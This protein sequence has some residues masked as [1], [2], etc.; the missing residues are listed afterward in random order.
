VNVRRVTVDAYAIPFRRPLV[1]ARRTIAERRGFVVRLEGEDGTVGVGEAAPHPLAAEAAAPGEAE[2]VR[3]AAAWLVGAST[4]RLGELL[5]ALPCAPAWIASGIDMA[6]HDLA[7]R[8]RGRAVTEL[9]G[10]ERPA[11]VRVSAIVDGEDDAGCARAAVS[12][13]RS[14][15]RTV[16]IKLGSDAGAAL[17]RVRALRAAMPWLAVRGDVNGGWDEATAL[18]ACAALAALGLEWIEQPLP[19]GEARAL[20]RLRRSSALPI[21][22]DEAVTGADAVRE[23]AAHRAVDAVVLKLVQVGGLARGL[24][25]ARAAAAADLAVAVTTSFE[26]SIGTAAALHLACAVPGRLRDCGLATASLLAGDLVRRPLAEG[27]VMVLPRGPGLGVE[28]DPDALER[29]RAG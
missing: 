3:A 29:W 21:A 23:L 19:P 8:A 26:S 18:G 15:F 11:A 24:E 9:L 20:A 7:A 16:K 5:A 4:E 17:A 25:T 13:A 6:L 27:P 28:L 14:G 10:G 1:T 12:A 2:T 22:A